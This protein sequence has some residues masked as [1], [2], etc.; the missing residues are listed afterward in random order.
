MK[1]RR[2][3]AVEAVDVGRTRVSHTWDISRGCA[4]DHCFTADCDAGAKQVARRASLSTT[5]ADSRLLRPDSLVASEDV[6]RPSVVLGLWGITS[7]ILFIVPD[8]NRVA[9]E[10]NRKETETVT[11][12]RVIAVDLL[13]L[14]PGRRVA[15]ED[16]DRTS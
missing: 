11:S 13:L 9:F 12:F 7:A 2:R 14:G 4:D 15:H 5:R 3:R 8:D 1:S 10:G 16:V 6:G